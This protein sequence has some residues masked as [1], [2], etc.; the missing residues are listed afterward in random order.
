MKVTRVDSITFKDE[1]G[2]VLIDEVTSNNLHVNGK[3][4]KQKRHKE[5]RFRVV[6]RGETSCELFEKVRLQNGF[7]VE[8]QRYFSDIRVMSIYDMEDKI[9]I[10]TYYDIAGVTIDGNY[11]SIEKLKENVEETYDFCE[12]YS[13]YTSDELLE[14]CG[15]YDCYDCEGC[16]RDHSILYS[17]KDIKI[18]IAAESNMAVIT[19]NK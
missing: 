15:G 9:L 11:V 8:Y 2:T 17:Y 12:I 10:A 6:K 16:L 1:L 14:R 13:E 19:V 7:D 4:V 3:S 18:E 5:H